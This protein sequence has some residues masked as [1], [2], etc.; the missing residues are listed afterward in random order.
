MTAACLT[1]GEEPSASLDIDK[2]EVV[3]ANVLMDGPSTDNVAGVADRYFLTAGVARFLPK[4]PGRLSRPRTTS[5]GAPAGTQ[6]ATF[7][8]IWPEISAALLNVT[9][10]QRGQDKT[11]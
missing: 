11:L 7:L 5:W 8:I 3:S 2:R 9:Y 4:E 1:A 6:K 10:V